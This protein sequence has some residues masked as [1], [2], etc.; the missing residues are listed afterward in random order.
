MGA[1]FLVEAA[2][3]PM[4][5]WLDIAIRYGLPTLL[6]IGALWKLWPMIQEFIAAERE[7]AKR[8]EERVEKTTAKYEDSIKGHLEATRDIALQFA[9]AMEKS[10][11]TNAETARQVGQLVQAV[12]DLRME[13]KQE[14][15]FQKRRTRK[16]T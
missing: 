3:P 13:I 7:R 4:N 14:R 10:T 12:H 8:L 6:L 5:P 16:A 1:F 11:N 15:E 2:S 9:D